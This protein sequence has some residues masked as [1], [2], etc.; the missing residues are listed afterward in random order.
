MNSLGSDYPARLLATHEPPCLSPYQPTHRHHPENQ[1]DPIRF[2]N[3][4]K[5]MEQALRRK[6]PTRQVQPLLAPFEALAD[7]DFWNHGQPCPEV[8]SI[9]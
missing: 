9:Y 1:Q 7:H 8:R 3:L 5:A 2:R 4:V 6:Y